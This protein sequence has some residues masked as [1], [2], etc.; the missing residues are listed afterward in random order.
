MAV[1]NTAEDNPSMKDFWQAVIVELQNPDGKTVRGRFASREV[2]RNLEEYIALLKEENYLK[3]YSDICYEY[4][5]A[6]PKA[7]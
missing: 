7:D 2:F 6:L 4:A 1:Q 3:M 5:D